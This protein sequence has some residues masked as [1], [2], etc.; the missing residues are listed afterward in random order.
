MER[1]IELTY[2]LGYPVL[3]ETREIELARVPVNGERLQD[4]VILHPRYVPKGVEHELF[5]AR[6][7]RRGRTL[8]LFLDEPITFN[9]VQYGILNFKGVGADAD[10]D[11]VIQPEKWYKPRI[12]DS[13]PFL[14]ETWVPRKSADD[15]GR[16]WGALT[17]GKARREF[18]ARLFQDYHFQYAP[19][20]ALNEVPREITEYI[21]Y[22]EHG[23][24]RHKLV[25]LVRGLQINIRFENSR[26]ALRDLKYD[27]D[28]E[29]IASADAKLFETQVLLGQRGKMIRLTGNVMGNRFLNGDFTDAENY[30]VD[31]LDSGIS[32]HFLTKLIT[33]VMWSPL[34]ERK[35]Q[36]LTLIK[37]ET[38]FPL[39]EVD[40]EQNIWTIRDKLVR[41]LEK[42]IKKRK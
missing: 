19:H 28:L 33:S 26:D 34:V 7:Y 6:V 4:S 22:V 20:L 25:Q 24:G 3:I 27:I 40:I 12:T 13:W 21:N 11:L 5:T 17:K 16:I 18:P 37:E 14:V 29:A 30:C 15:F 38:G 41:E 8:D 23:K 32:A 36:Y 2:H 31:E 9:G 1:P 10:R 42:R 39:K 35:Q